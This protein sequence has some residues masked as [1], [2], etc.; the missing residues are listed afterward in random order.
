MECICPRA[1]DICA[2]LHAGQLDV[3]A[4]QS[5]EDLVLGVGDTHYQPQGALLARPVDIL[6]Y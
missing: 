6:H 5:L 2:C 3:I 4:H 1:T